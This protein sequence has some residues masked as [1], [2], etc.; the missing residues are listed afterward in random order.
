MKIGITSNYK[1]YS[2]QNNNK[3][4]V[5]F[6]AFDFEPAALS[7]LKKK[8]TCDRYTIF[9]A[10]ESGMDVVARFKGIVGYF[11][12]RGL[13]KLLQQHPNVHFT[14]KEAYQIVDSKNPLNTAASIINANLIKV[15]LQDLHCILST[16]PIKET[17]RTLANLE[18][19]TDWDKYDL[20]GKYSRNLRAALGLHSPPVNFEKPLMQ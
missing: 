3:Q 16:P 20:E 5:N 13:T 10:I 2:P 19:P 12:S 8:F 7:Y 4:S 17:E 1:T 9:I 11:R 14:S 18:S 15:T 6:G